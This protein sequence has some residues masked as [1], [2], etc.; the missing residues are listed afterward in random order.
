MAVSH[1]LVRFLFIREIVSFLLSHSR[2][3]SSIYFP[4]SLRRQFITVVQSQR[5]QRCGRGVS[6]PTFTCTSLR[7]TTSLLVSRNSSESSRRVITDTVSFCHLMA[8]LCLLQHQTRANIQHQPYSYPYPYPCLYPAI[9]TSDD[10]RRLLRQR[11]TVV[12]A[13]S[14][15]QKANLRKLDFFQ[16][17]GLVMPSRP[18]TARL[19]L[20]RLFKTRLTS[21]FVRSSLGQTRL[22]ISLVSVRRDGPLVSSRGPQSRQ[23]FRRDFRLVSSRVEACTNAQFIKVRISFVQNN[24][25]ITS[26]DDVL[27]IHVQA[28]ISAS[29]LVQVY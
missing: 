21:V 28:K 16:H 6:L 19:V 18:R 7:Q 12:A 10:T 3:G 25:L 2:G 5:R 23:D 13:F 27:K 22:E 17:L 4:F 14:R 24:I 15:L 11:R 29:L 8:T 9:F 26:S 1:N 20:S